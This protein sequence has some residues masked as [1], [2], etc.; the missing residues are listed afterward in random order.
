M[1]TCS[2]LLKSFLILGVV[3]LP[4][5][6]LAQ[7]DIGEL[8]KS[9]PADATK[10]VA[11]YANPIF[12]GLGVGL[13][14]GW[15]NTATTKRP[16]RFD[17]RITATAAF[18]PKSDRYYDVNDLNLAN[19]RPV[20]KYESIGSTAFGNEKEGAEMEF[21][22]NG[23][24]S[25]SFR[26]PKGSGL[27]FVPSPQVQ[28]TLGVLNNIDLAFRWVPKVQL[29][30]DA[31]NLSLFGIGAKF[32]ILPMLLGKSASIR[33]VDL[34]LAFGYSKLNYAIPL[35]INEQSYSNQKLDIE[36]NGFSA[37]AIISK[38]LLFFT[39]F[40]SVGYNTSKSDLKA[41]GDYEFDVPV[42]PGHPS[43]KQTYTN[44]VS[45]SQKDVTGIKASLGFQLQ[46]SFFKIYG[47]V[48][49]AKYSYANAGIGFGIGK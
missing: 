13:N 49:Q 39:P 28:L 14:S 36:M 2:S 37:E 33:P 42:T 38:K 17:L 45:L 41:L 31:G 7:D 12:K 1:K 20:N 23:V 22:S 47:S 29:G 15:N 16:L 32:E 19:I 34:A 27:S 44:P 8:F 25:G 11:A 9:G 5:Q 35:N 30:N 26:L 46:F 10:L 3:L 21:Y 40:A 4:L 48:T 6:L 43:G 18:V 24:S